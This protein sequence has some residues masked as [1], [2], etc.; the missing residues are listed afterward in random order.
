MDAFA[1]L[2]APAL[3]IKNPM[4]ASLQMGEPEVF[5]YCPGGHIMQFSPQPESEL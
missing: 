4:G 3:L 5:W 2:E 1:K